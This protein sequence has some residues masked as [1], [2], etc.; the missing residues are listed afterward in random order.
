TGT[1]AD[2]S[3]NSLGCRIYH[4][5]AP[6]AADPT[7][8]CPHAGPAGSGACGPDCDG[9]CSIEASACTGDNQQ[10]ATNDECLAACNAFHGADGGYANDSTTSGN[11]FACH[12][13][14]LTVAA[15]L[16]GGQA[17]TH[18]PHTKE[19]AAGTPCGG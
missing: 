6:A 12:M 9:F 5:G 4:A 8:H 14:H 16:D 17:I 13:Y 1:L 3:G 10:F 19:T 11:T 2:M 18:C 15:Q 7:T